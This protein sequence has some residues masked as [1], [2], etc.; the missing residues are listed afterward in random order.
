M[1]L[2]TLPVV[3]A[4]R[5]PDTRKLLPLNEY[6]LFIVSFSGGKDSLALVLHLL[7]LGV[8]KEKIELWHQDVDGGDAFMDWN[9]TPAYCRAIA[10]ALGIEI[11]FQYKQGGFRREMLR[12]DSLTAPTV[13]EI[14]KGVWSQ[15]GGERGKN[16]TR[17][18][19]PQVSP[20]LSVRWC[21]AYLK[22][23]VAATAMNNSP[24]LDG[25]K[26]CYLSGERR[27]ESTARSKY[28]EREP[29]RTD[30]LDD[31]LTPEQ[32]AL[33]GKPYKVRKVKRC[34]HWRAV[35][36]WSERQVWDIIQ[37]YGIVPHPAYY[38]GWG[39]LSCMACIFGNADQW[40]SLRYIAPERFAEIA[41]YETEFGCT[42]KR[43]AGVGALADKGKPY[44]Q[45]QD[46]DLVALALGHTYTAPVIAPPHLWTLPAGAYSHSGGPT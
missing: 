14:E 40:A 4:D 2:L 25:R 10:N 23:D 43:G 32:R 28:A 8:P 41:G 1:S 9:V 18:K 21:S 16:A 46:A 20:D 26:I 31:P 45:C 34:D 22:I 7:D 12:Q 30:N 11:F 27:Q 3:A 37:R 33:K 44:P 19:F 17:R 5:R 42:I 35:I 15:A 39:R 38:L 36:D 29:H 13:F 6:D 24:R